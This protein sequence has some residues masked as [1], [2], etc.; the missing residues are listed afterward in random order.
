LKGW[1]EITL[2]VRSMFFTDG[3]LQEVCVK[4]YSFQV[5]LI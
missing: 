2:P 4:R 1:R 3:T 5:F